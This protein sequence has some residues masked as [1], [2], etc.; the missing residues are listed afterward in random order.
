LTISKIVF[1]G[2]LSGNITGQRIA[3]EI[4]KEFKS[5][6]YDILNWTDLIRLWL[7]SYKFSGIYITGSR[8][9]LGFFRD[10]FFLFPFLIASKKIYIHIHGDDIDNLLRSRWRI[11]KFISH[12]VYR[13]SVF[14]S[15]NPTHINQFPKLGSFEIV[16]N[17]TRFDV[18]HNINRKGNIRRFIYLST[19][20]REKGIFDWIDI[21]KG[22]GVEYKYDIIG[23][24]DL[25]SLDLVLFRDLLNDLENNNFDIVVHGRVEGDSLIDL[26]RSSTDL[27]YVSK[28]PTENMPLVLLEAASQGLAL[29][30]TMHR[31]LHRRFGLKTNP[32]NFNFNISEIAQLILTDG[33]QN[34]H[35]NSKLI[36]E[37]YSKKKYLKSIAAIIS[38]TY[39]IKL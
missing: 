5:D 39:Q 4:L 2:P 17:F 22:L 33:R 9:G 24:F 15:C 13:R 1:V 21:I 14:I 11:L 34:I 7:F 18:Y 8:S 29:H 20:S 3:F 31:N 38:K 30:V 37:N 10:L 26:L 35:Y 19:V 6:F 36:E 25:S 27:I 16:E 12:F 32:I 28:H 23:D